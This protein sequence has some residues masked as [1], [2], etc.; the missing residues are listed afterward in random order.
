M[1]R[2]F[3]V[4]AVMALSTMLAGCL[5]RCDISYRQHE[6]EYMETAIAS[7]TCNN[8]GYYLFWV[9]PICSG[10]PWQDGLLKDWEPERD[11]FDDHVTLDA[12]MD[13]IRLAAKEAGC[14]RLTQV[15]TEVAE[16]SVWS[17][18]LIKRKSITTT[19]RILKNKTER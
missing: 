2:I 14:N 5:A 4:L 12:N 18:F 16:N 15:R 19:A 9:W 17:F 8:T 3:T 7:V 1:R 13:M 6:M 11:W 10:A